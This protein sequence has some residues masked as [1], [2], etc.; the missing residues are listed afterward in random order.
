MSR[1]QSIERA[2]AVLSALAD[3]PI[4]VTEVAERAELPKSTAARMLASLSPRGRRRAGPG[5]H[6]LP[7]RGRGSRRWPRAS[8]PAR[9]LVAIARPILVELASAAGE[10]A[11]LSVPDGVVVHYVDQVDTTP[12]GP[13][14]RLD[15]DAG[16]DARGLV[17][18]G[19]PRPH[20]LGRD[21]RALPRD[22]AGRVHGPDAHRLRRAAR[23]AAAR[24][25]STATPGSARS[26]RRASTASPRPSPARTARSS[27]PST[28]TGR[29]TASRRPGARTASR[30]WSFGRAEPVGAAAGV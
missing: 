2:F 30:A 5:R 14:P 28:S 22:A 13:G 9:S 19:L 21:A 26:S 16:A 1:V 27:P 29:R 4:G 11:G 20:E 17:R 12:P 24:S 7:A 18:P 25:S 3:G 15:R 6:P 8:L 10:A 23:A